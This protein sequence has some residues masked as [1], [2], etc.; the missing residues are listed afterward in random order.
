MN[1]V[2]QGRFE[3]LKKCWLENLLCTGCFVGWLYSIGTPLLSFQIISSVVIIPTLFAFS[4]LLFS[5][6]NNWLRLEGLVAADN[7]LA[8]W[9]SI[10]IISLTIASAFFM[11][12]HFDAFHTD[13][14]HYQTYYAIAAT[15]M[16]LLFSSAYK[17]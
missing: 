2:L 7:N 8:V 10:G 16:F 13:A 6:R 14:R 17:K 4:D 9:L 3:H 11:A 15:L 5:N 1:R 12:S